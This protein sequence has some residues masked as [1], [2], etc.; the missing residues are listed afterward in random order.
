MLT[1]SIKPPPRPTKQSASST[2]RTLDGKL[3]YANSQKTTRI[4]ESTVWL[5]TRHKISHNLTPNS[6]RLKVAKGLSLAKKEVKLSL[7]H[8]VKFRPGTTTSQLLTKSQ[9]A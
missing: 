8:S 3:M 7:K 2:A 9:T 4:M 6:T 5:R 1:K